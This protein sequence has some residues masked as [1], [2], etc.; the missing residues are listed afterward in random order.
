[1]LQWVSRDNI[2][3]EEW[4]ACIERCEWGKVYALYE[5]LDAIASQQWEALILDDYE[6]VMPVPFRRKW[7]I[8]YAFRPNFC[9]QL[10]VFARNSKLGEEGLESFIKA[11]LK[12]YRFMDYPMNHANRN[13][14]YL[15]GRTNYILHLN[16]PHS[17]VEA[18]YSN[19][20][21]RNLD[22]AAKSDLT[23]IE[24]LEPTKVVEIYKR[25]WQGKHR[26]P[27]KD[28][29]QMLWLTSQKPSPFQSYFFGV[30][31]GGELISACMVLKFKN[32]L[33][34]PMSGISDEGRKY[35]STA[36]MIDAIL[37]LF[38]NKNLVFDFEG[39]EIPSVKYFYSKFGAVNEEF[40]EL[41]RFFF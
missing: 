38:S 24:N 34:F 40:T 12:R 33:Y 11:F 16:T 28:Y 31:H 37:Q 19:D 4:N 6:W 2:H 5:Y 30:S 10:G 25:A 22:K 20:L 17:E 36:F 21:K 27:E 32:R 35:N 15:R 7:G 9:Q 23:F 14:K 29:E 39:S 41:K 8:K 18:Q 3:K 13:E 1:M 26:I